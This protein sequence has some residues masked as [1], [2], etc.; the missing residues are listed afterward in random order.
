MNH[1]QTQSGRACV[2][3]AV[4]ALALLSAVALAAPAG[5]PTPL[6]GNPGNVY[7][8][9][10]EVV[11]AVPN[12]PGAWQLVDAADAPVAEPVV[13]NGKAN[14]GKLPVGFYRLKPKGV[15]TNVWV[16]VGVL[17]PLAAPTPA[18]SPVALDVAMAWFYSSEQMGVAANLCALAGVNW[19]RDR[20]S[21]GEMEQERGQWAA[22][23]TRYDATAKVQSEAGL[24]VLQVNHSSPRW[25]NPNHKRFP[26]DLRDAHRFYREMARRWQGKV[27]A[28]EPWNEAD[29]DV[30]GGHTGAEMA[31]LQKASYL[32]LKAG[33]PNVIACL[34]VFA[35][36][37]PAQLE[38]LHANE[39]WPYFDTFN[40]HHYDAFERYPSIYGAFRAVSAGKPLWVSECARP[41]KWAGDDKLKEPAD[42]DL[43]VQAERVAKTYALSVHEG[44]VATFYFLLP[45][46]V[47]GQ[48]QFGI[49]RPD[50]TPRPAYVALAAVGRF[51]AD[52]KPL[53]RLQTGT[54]QHAYAFRVRADGQERLLAIAWNDQA[55]SDWLLPV[56]PAGVYD[57]LGR[58]REGQ[59]TLRLTTAP[60]FA[61]LPTGAES[62]LTFAARPPK[63]PE[64]LGGTMSPVVLQASWPQER[65][66]LELSAYR[67]A[68]DQEQSI[69]VWI[70]NF[71]AESVTGQWRITAP[72]S[73]T[74]R[75]LDA[76]TLAPGERKEVALGFK[77][78][79]NSGPQTGALALV[80]DFGAAGRTVLSVRLTTQEKP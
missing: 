62:K 6:P 30:F 78:Q 25:A 13:Q 76:V 49:L 20:L 9:G 73:W 22:A 65:V 3:G 27:L 56:R 36:H 5:I 47:E 10:Q 50:L 60:L 19:V 61:L 42:A 69:P 23:T 68:R 51:M 37:R 79:G 18:T 17:S 40:L 59:N 35:M 57:Y 64:R 72:E 14:L 12:A 7:L 80:G 70:Y 32:G 31:A 39:A 77:I 53:G 75:T 11:V 46:Y 16:S 63:A 8:K 58:E 2:V 66:S 24:R 21:W 71:G 1:S 43:V 55:T 33:N 26:A 34:N 38:D 4:A 41:V 74:V 54:N 52:A 29:I 44:S 48:T 28:F 67:I 45:H 15:P